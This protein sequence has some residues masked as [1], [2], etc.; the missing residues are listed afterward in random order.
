MADLWKTLGYDRVAGDIA[1]R[2]GASPDIRLIQG[3][4]GVG[5]SW[6]A[7]GIGGMWESAGGG[8]VV[9]E[10]DSL[11]SEISLYPFGI[12]MGSLSSLFPESQ[13]S[14]IEMSSEAG[15]SSPR[16]GSLLAA[17]VKALAN[18]QTGARRERGVLLD[19]AEQDALFKLAK[20]GRERPLLVIA[21]NLHWWDTKSLEFLCRL[22]DVRMTEAFPFLAAMRVLAVETVPPYQSVAHPEARAALLEPRL[23]DPVALGHVPREGFEDV[24]LA[25]GAP[26]RPSSET[27]DLIY[28]FSGGHLVLA[29]RCAERLRGDEAGEFLTTYDSANFVSKLLNERLHSLGNAGEK[30]IG[31]LQV[32]ALSGLTFRRDELVCATGIDEG[33]TRRLLRRCRDENVLELRDGIGRFVH[34]FYREYFLDMIGEDRIAIQEALGDCLRK[35]SPA[36]YESRCIN[37]LEVEREDA[38]AAFAIQAALQ[39]QREGLPWRELPAPALRVMA[40]R[41]LTWIA[42]RFEIASDHAKHFR[43]VDCLQTLSNLPHDLP[44][45]LNAEADYVR[46]AALMTTR[47][48]KDRAEA[49]AM[50]EEWADL[51]DQEAELGLRLMRLRLYAM[52]M[53]VDKKPGLKLENELRQHLRKRAPFDAAATDALY[54]LDRCAGG[55]HPPERALDMMA[56]AVEHFGPRDNE[57]IL[58]RPVEYYLSLVNFGAELIAI[59]SYAKAME[60]H[61]KL[62]RLIN[63]Y[64]SGVF[65]RR[66]YAKINHLLAAYRTGAV[67]IE[68]AVR[69]Q[70]EIVRKHDTPN[71]P[72]HAENGLACYLMLAGA[73]EDAIVVFDRLCEELSR[74]PDPEPSMVYL[75][76]ANRCAARYVAGETDGPRREWAQL[77]DVVTEI[78][79]VTRMAMIH[80]H[81]MLADVM[82]DG[83]RVSAKEFDECL[84]D[85]PPPGFEHYWAQ[86]GRAFRMPAI[87]WWR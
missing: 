59:G 87:Q 48:E 1:E 36:N 84:L 68:G 27:A 83:Q 73:H 7:K 50:L 86:H 62:D 63:S 70:R 20:L 9:A 80:R 34:D 30:A 10:G 6:L 51:V 44:T 46:A 82:S 17:S 28:K 29:S 23:T 5:K 55:M 58:R 49:E 18:R 61:S 41:G 11:R 65:P 31:M 37:A 71:D 35:L 16:T 15:R 54:I 74:R 45:H 2:L 69:Q 40:T 57:A 3:P 43:T 75:I 76:R 26:R 24:L 52:A 67:G 78:P 66:D 85:H 79:Y 22:R 4:P 14:A 39:R 81:R 13:A 47:G 56:R 77:D 64:E 33:E 53:R 42:E 38:A 21:D 19:R 8:V 72:F 25:L 32:A 12:A 60:I